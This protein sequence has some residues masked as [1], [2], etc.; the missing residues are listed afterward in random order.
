MHADESLTVFVHLE[1]VQHDDGR[2]SVLTSV[3]ERR[4]KR[5]KQLPLSSEAESTFGTSAEAL[6]HGKRIVLEALTHTHPNAEVRLTDKEAD[7]GT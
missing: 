7:P 2:Y 6:A 5:V 1:S 4:G 3:M